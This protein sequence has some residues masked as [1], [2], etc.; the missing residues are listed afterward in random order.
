VP[1]KIIRKTNVLQRASVSLV[2]RNLFLWVPKSNYWGDPDITTS[3]DSNVPGMAGTNPA[4][5][6]NY[7]FNLLVSF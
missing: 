3:G 6:R 2:G 4:A 7:G 5:S 1:D